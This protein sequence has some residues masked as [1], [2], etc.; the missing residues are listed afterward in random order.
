MKLEWAIT[1][2][3]ILALAV[4]GFLY[5]RSGARAP[6]ETETTTS[7]STYLSLAEKNVRFPK[8]PE[9]STPDG[10]INTDGKAVTLEELKGKVVLLD[11]WTYSCI[12][13]QRTI[14]Y[15]NAWYK[16]YKAQ[17]LIIIGLHTPEFAFEKVQANVERAVKDFAIEYPVVLDNDFSTWNAYHNQYWPR[18]YLIDI[19]GFIVYDHAGEGEYDVTERAIQK[20]LM[21]RKARLGIHVEVPQDIATSAVVSVDPNNVGSPETYFGASRNQYLGNG[22]PGKVGAFQA[23]ELGDVKPDTLYLIGSWNITPE[24]AETPA[25][26]GI[27]EVGSDRIDYRYQ[28]KS[29]YFVA[30]SKS[31]PIEVEVL[32]DSAPVKQEVK[33]ADVYYKNGRS[34]IKIQEN[35]LYKLIEDTVSGTHFLELIISKPGLQ[36]FT[37]TFG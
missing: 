37:F 36:A 7:T 12:N 10:F 3:I 30:G 21:E 24:Y 8:A 2:V 14:P 18:K 6:S 20:A 23:N 31:A 22:V 11:I 28:A 4:G 17:G 5:W 16:K 15:L 35:R 32:R 25:S 29:V 33:G 1:V 19:D 9:I 27:S 13:C 26:V 34:Y